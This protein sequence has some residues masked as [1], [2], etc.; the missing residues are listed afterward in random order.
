MNGCQLLQTAQMML[1]VHLQ[2]QTISV[3][4]SRRPV[5]LEQSEA[6]CHLLDSRFGLHRRELGCAD[7][8]WRRNWNVLQK[9]LEIGCHQVEAELLVTDDVE[10]SGLESDGFEQTESKIFLQGLQQQQTE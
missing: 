2:I 7:P 1:A 4:W 6:W 5:E 10:S 8:A 9:M 3:S